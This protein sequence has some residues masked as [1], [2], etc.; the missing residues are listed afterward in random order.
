MAATPQYGVMNLVGLRSG[1]SYSK[2]VYISDV[3]AALVTFD[4]GAGAGAAT[5]DNWVAPEPV[6]L[7][8][9]AQ[10]TG[11]ADTTK[12]QLTS[13]GV[14]TGDILRYTVHLTT[15]NNRPRLGVAFPKG[16]EIGAIQLA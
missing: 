14:P 5:R 10:V 7:V 3:A 13:N 8:D 15:L 9:Y 1:Q 16:A 2:D 11:T 12:L 6:V 4:A